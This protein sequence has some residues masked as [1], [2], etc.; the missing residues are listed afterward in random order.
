MNL[1]KIIII[2]MILLLISIGAMAVIIG[3]NGKTVADG[4]IQANTMPEVPTQTEKQDTSLKVEN[5]CNRFYAVK[6]CVEKFYTYYG[7]IYQSQD[8]N[9]LMPE[10]VKAK[11]E[12]N[13]QKYAESLYQ[14][15]APEYISFSGITKENIISKLPKMEIPVVNITNMYVSEKTTNVFVYIVSGTLRG[16]QNGELQNFQVMLEVDKINKAFRIYLQDY[17]R[18]K[19]KNIKIGN[20]IEIQVPSGIEKNTYNS[21]EAKNILEETYVNDLFKKWKE[22]VV[23][24]SELAYN[25][26]DEEYKNKKFN[27]ISKF[28][29][30][31]KN[32]LRK[33]VIMELDKYQKT[34]KDGY[35]Q[36]VCIDKA[37]NYYIFKETSIMNYTMLL[38]TYTVDQPEFIEKY[39]KMTE[40]QKVQ[41]NIQKVFDAINLGDYGY[42]YEKLDQTFKNTYFKTQTEFENYVKKNFFSNNSIG[43][44]DYQKNEEIYLYNIQISNKQGAGTIQKKVVM[45][46]K[47]GTD[48]VMSFNVE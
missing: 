41:A 15:L 18:E 17:L 37:G 3:L 8:N 10:E 32:H 44:G 20:E 9:S 16:R 43:Y 23:Y 25:H 4:N 33:Y 24:Q 12:E 47:E 5:D 2:L 27:T 13:K 6:G 30:Y 40:N 45:Q 38:D 36:Y 29:A 19:Y 21:Y 46:L 7:T 22:E 42:M 48:F 26:I 31:R 14:M 39:A 11:Q 34:Q 35:T 1:K 28:Q